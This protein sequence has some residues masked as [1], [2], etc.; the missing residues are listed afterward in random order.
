M[1]AR[2]T[3]RWGNFIVMLSLK[4]RASAA[5]VAVLASVLILVPSVAVADTVDPTPIPA[6]APDP[7]AVTVSPDGGTL[8][9]A[10]WTDAVWVYDTSDH[11]LIDTIT[12]SNQPTRM[13]ISPDGSRLYV[14]MSYASAVSI[15]DTS[16]NSV[17]DTVSVWPGGISPHG[18]A[19]SPDGTHVYV[20]NQANASNS[21]SV[22]RTSDN[23]EI[24][25]IP[26]GGALPTS[27]AV[28]PDSTRVY[29]TNLGSGTVS[30][31]DAVTWTV[32]LTIPVAGAYDIAISPD[33]SLAYVT[34]E[35]SD[36]V[37]VIDTATNTVIDAVAVSG[38]FA[39][40]ITP[41][42][43]R[44]YITT[45]AGNVVVVETTTNTVAETLFVGTQAWD[46]TVTPDGST[47]YVAQNNQLDQVSIIHIEA[48]P[49]ISTLTLPDGVVGTP[50]AETITATGTPDPTFT[51][52]VPD[53]LPP[54]VTLGSDGE[55]FGEPTAA[56]EYTFS[57]T[58][59]NEHGADTHEYTV[60]I[61][62]PPAITTLTLPN[63][64]VGEDYLEIIA[65]TGTEPLTFT[66]D[67]PD[68]LPPGLALG[69][70]GE[71]SGEPTAAGEYSFSVTA[72]NEHGTD[73][74]E[75]TINVEAPPV[76][77]T[78]TLPDGIVG[79]N[80][81]ET[82]VATGTPAPTFT[83]SGE[84]PPG[85]ILS[86]GGE[87]N[88]KPSAAGEYDFSVTAM[89]E[90]GTDTRDYTVTIEAAALPDDPADEDPG[91]AATGAANLL[92]SIALVLLLAAVGTAL[93]AWRRRA[94]S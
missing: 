22:I 41:D 27:V 47:A 37:S 44:L 85:L 25:E 56:G 8:Y 17:V 1:F 79:E 57:V 62:A 66:L 11:S 86:A 39:I 54:G 69:T 91:L 3:R 21:V 60:V 23:T 38:P 65:A 64:V 13:A 77:S 94:T 29:V 26:T 84:L 70:D 74:H 7:V 52:E 55:L 78:L 33:G 2:V 68:T 87:L 9:V 6:P 42:G 58:A 83:Y 81:L 71:L 67:V 32:V 46:I 76:I 24:A 82:I 31:I 35:S 75:Y 14:T 43:N 12:L 53:T 36:L 90:H 50:Y 45:V 19:V 5:L 28:S 16:N 18:V 92:P 63:G 30:V 59:T 10:G 34:Q 72:T 48:P 49:A 20:A 88:G 80:Y 40:A 61:E 4:R 15:I 73:T 89:N 51:L 93:V